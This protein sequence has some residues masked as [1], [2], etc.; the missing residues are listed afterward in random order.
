[1]GLTL[2]ELREDIYDNLGM[3]ASD[4]SA[5]KIDQYLNRSYWELTKKL[6]FRQAD[7]QVIL[8]MVTGQNTYPISDYVSDFDSIRHITILEYPNTQNLWSEVTQT[9][10][11]NLMDI[12]DGTN[13]SQISPSKYARYENNIVFNSVPSNAYSVKIFYRKS[14]GNI[15][16]AGPSIPEEWHEALVYGAVARAWRAEGSDMKSNQ[17]AAYQFQLISTMIET[18]TKENR[19]YS[20]STAK[21]LRARYP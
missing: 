17:A 14:L 6:K 2:A 5:G 20:H 4:I 18:E 16:S 7:A 13:T 3:D 10:Y 12:E 8:T 19:D 1:M 9:D 15:L 21:I 11:T